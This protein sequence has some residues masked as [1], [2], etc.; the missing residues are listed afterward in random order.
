MQRNVGK[1]YS[2]RNRAHRQAMAVAVL[3]S[4]FGSGHNGDGDNCRTSP[5]IDESTHVD[6]VWPICNLRELTPPNC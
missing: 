2:D 3:G 5:P 1:C 6:A 4:N